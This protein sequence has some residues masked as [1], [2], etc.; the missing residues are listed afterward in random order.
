MSGG[1]KDINWESVFYQSLNLSHSTS[2]SPYRPCSW[3]TIARLRTVRSVSGS[4][5]PSCFSRPASAR[6]CSNLT[7]LCHYLCFVRTI[8]RAC[9]V[10]SVL[11][12]SG[13]GCLSLCCELAPHM[14]QGSTWILDVQRYM[15][16]AKI[17]MNPKQERRGRRFQNHTCRKEEGRKYRHSDSQV[18]GVRPVLSLIFTTQM[19]AGF[20]LSR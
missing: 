13:S 6:P 11:A 8:A 12:Y 16:N 18:S 2:A 5:G 15:I 19:I 7:L 17:N 4:S 10:P 20:G 14:I 1:S 3:Q 9:A